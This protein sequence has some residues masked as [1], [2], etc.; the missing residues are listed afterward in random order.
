VKLGCPEEMA[1]QGQLELQVHSAI[2]AYLETG[3]R[4][5]SQEPLGRHREA[6]L[7]LLE[8]RAMLG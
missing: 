4:L 8:L 7:A 6:R 3:D 2:Q 1:Y 5:D